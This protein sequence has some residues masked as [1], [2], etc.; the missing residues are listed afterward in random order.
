MMDRARRTTNYE[1]NANHCSP[2]MRHAL[3]R[4]NK[5]SLVIPEECVEDVIGSGE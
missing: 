5:T 2:L 3:C 1:A 4:N